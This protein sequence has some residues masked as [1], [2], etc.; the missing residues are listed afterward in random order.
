ML[1]AIH[2]ESD[3]PESASPNPFR[4][5]LEDPETMRPKF[6]KLAGEP[7]QGEIDEHNL[8]HAN[9]RSWCP[10]CVKG[11]ANSFPHTQHINR[12]ADTPIVSID[13]AF[14]NDDKDKGED[15]DKG[16]PIIVLTYR[17]TKIKR[18]RVVPRTGVEPYAVYRIKKRTWSNWDT[19]ISYSRAIKR[20]ASRL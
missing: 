14:M 4:D 17:E 1:E 2:P 11:R 7:T 8:N 10:H 20:T 9:F 15:K 13:Y 5:D 18:A 16:M 3:D 6:R 19:I 12:T